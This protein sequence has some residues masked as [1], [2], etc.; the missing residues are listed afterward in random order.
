MLTPEYEAEIK[1]LDEKIA[2]GEIE[3]D[4]SDVP[5]SDEFDFKYAITNAEY[6]AMGTSERSEYFHAALA[7]KEADRAARKA[8][9]EAETTIAKARQLAHQG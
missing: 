6:Q 3:V 5:E 9:Q 7:A 1:A 2:N 4:C 8:Q